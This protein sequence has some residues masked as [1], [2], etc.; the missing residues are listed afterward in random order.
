MSF[1]L[2]LLANLLELDAERPPQAAVSISFVSYS[3]DPGMVGFG[4]GTRIH[5]DAIWV[6]L[7][8]VQVRPAASCKRSQ[9]RPVVAG[10]L[11]AE[12]VKR[13]TTDTGRSDVG[14]YCAFEF[15]LRR[16]RGRAGPRNELRGASIVITGRRADGVRFVLRSRLDAAPLLRAREL[17]GISVTAPR[18]DWIVGVDV[19]R[20]MAG[21]DLALAEPTGDREL[22]ID[23]KS[24]ADL[25]AAFDANVEAGFALFDDR[26]GDRNL[27]QAERARPIATHQ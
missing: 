14:R 8:D 21:V 2:A 10:P 13:S 17:E 27:N 22:R 15:Q 5:I 19:S 3:S 6:A 26:D 12:L 16:S 4:D 20:W 7:Q 1:I 24:N 18:A 25:L 23:D 9:A 11:T